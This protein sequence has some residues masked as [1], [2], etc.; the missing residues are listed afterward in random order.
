MKI[1]YKHFLYAKL[2]PSLLHFCTHKHIS[3]CLQSAGVCFEGWR[4][5][6]RLAWCFY[7]LV[8]HSTHREKCV[9]WRYTHQSVF[10]LF[11]VQLC[12]SCMHRNIR[13]CPPAAGNQS[14]ECSGAANLLSPASRWVTQVCSSERP[15]SH[16]ARASR[17]LAM[18]DRKAHFRL[19]KLFTIDLLIWVDSV[20][21][22]E[23]IIVG[24][25]P[26][27]LLAFGQLVLLVACYHQSKALPP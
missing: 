2:F 8:K 13:H 9:S 19:K 16:E 23:G 5:F 11:D 25:G 15:S 18:Q 12:S 10:C 6:C 24:E 17:N 22:S 21:A 7:L 20:P 27:E 4:L 26:L 14:W 3:T 1:E